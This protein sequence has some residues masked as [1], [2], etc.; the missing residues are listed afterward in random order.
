MISPE[1]SRLIALDRIGV[2]E[3]SFELDASREECALLAT[4]L[5]I[6]EV[7]SLRAEIAVKLIHGGKR[8][9]L[10]GR[11]QAELIQTCVVTLEP[12][13]THVNEEFTRHFTVE[14]SRLPVEVVIDMEEDDPPEPIEDGQID[15]GEAA[16]EH[17][18]LAM[19]SFPRRPDVSFA[20]PP[21]ASQ[22]EPTRI[23]PFE[24]LALP[25]K[26]I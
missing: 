9:R 1:F 8:V 24:L 22:L 10:K 13:A 7:C 2:K 11:V 21:E 12:V 6:P 19:D 23:S 4:R 14:E 20:P 16:A 5:G 17:L 26:K 18:A 3:K 15:M 25:R